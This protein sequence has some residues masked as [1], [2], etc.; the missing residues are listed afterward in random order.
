ME[1]DIT[2]KNSVAFSKDGKY[3]VVGCND[4]KIKVMNTETKKYMRTL[5]GHSESV[6]S[7]V[8][9][10]DNKLIVSGS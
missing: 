2:K 8:I 10:S 9:S 3:I 4:G 1:G 6:R 7:V 5:A